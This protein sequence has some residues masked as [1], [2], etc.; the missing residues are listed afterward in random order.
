MYL[1]PEESE[2][3]LTPAVRRATIGKGIL[4]GARDVK[5]RVVCYEGYRAEE[6]PRAIL[7]GDRRVEVAEILDRWRGTDHEY[8]K[9]RS[10]DR[11]I[12]L[13][14]LSRETQEWELTMMEAEK[15]IER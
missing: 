3:I 13:I 10:P 1:S 4:R 14:R 15:P 12:Y 11:T 6:T 8:V 2:R 9:F 5:I 7:L